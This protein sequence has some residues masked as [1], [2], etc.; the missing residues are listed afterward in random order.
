MPEILDRHGQKSRETYALGK[1]KLLWRANLSPSLPG[2]QRLVALETARSSPVGTDNGHLMMDSVVTRLL[3][4]V[5][6][7]RGR[8]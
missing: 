3:L 4:R 7:S 8:C 2:P 1:A 6:G 5:E